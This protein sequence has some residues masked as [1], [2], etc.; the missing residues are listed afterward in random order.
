MIVII[1]VVVVVVIAIAI[2]IAIVI[3]I[4]IIIIII[5]IIN[6][7]QVNHDGPSSSTFIIPMGPRSGR[8]KCASNTSR[9]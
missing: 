7:G 1:V 9:T 3:V 2:A 4:V 6:I 5:I 8:E